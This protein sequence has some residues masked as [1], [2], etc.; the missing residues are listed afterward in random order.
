MLELDRLDDCSI[1]VL[2]TEDFLPWNLL[3]LLVGQRCQTPLAPN[4]LLICTPARLAG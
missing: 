3:R 2:D 4:L 1:I